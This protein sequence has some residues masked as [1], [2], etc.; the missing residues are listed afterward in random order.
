M[1]RRGVARRPNGEA[2]S[3]AGR[4]R[5]ASGDGIAGHSGQDVRQVGKEEDDRRM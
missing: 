1:V 4:R 5:G 3:W 2:G